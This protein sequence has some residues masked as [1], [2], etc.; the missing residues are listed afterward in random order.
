MEDKND[1]LKSIEDKIQE[2]ETYKSIHENLVEAYTKELD[3]L[4]VRKDEKDKILEV[5]TYKSIHQNLVDSCQANLNHLYVAKGQIEGTLEKPEPMDLSKYIKKSKKTRKRLKGSW[6]LM[7]TPKHINS[8]LQSF[9]VKALT[10]FGNPCSANYLYQMT[11]KLSEN[12]MDRDHFNR[13]LSEACTKTFLMIPLTADGIKTTDPYYKQRYYALT[14][15]VEDD[16]LKP[17]F[18]IHK[19]DFAIKS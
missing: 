18:T 9:I 8:K 13:R 10:D 11:C 16:K 2:Q 14:E 7:Q 4:Y 17:E 6:A 3:Q 5:E 12:N 19:S 1:I 15:W